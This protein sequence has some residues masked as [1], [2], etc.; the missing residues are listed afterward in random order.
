MPTYNE[1]IIKSGNVIEVY[2]YENKIQ[3][4]FDKTENKCGR[5]CVANEENK[6]LN[7]EKVI[8]RARTSI[9]RIVNC[10]V[11]RNSKFVTLTFRED[12]KDLN[13]ANYE[14]NKFIKR[15]KYKIKR[16]I[17]YLTVIE[18]QDKNRDGVIH[19]H[20]IFFNLPYI[21][22]FALNRIWKNGF[23]RIN[24]IDNVDNVGAY[25]CKYMSKDNADVRLQEKKCF[26]TSQKLKQPIEILRDTMY[27]KKLSPIDKDLN[28]LIP[29]YTQSFINEYNSVDYKQYILPDY[30]K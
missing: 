22:N 25:V 8:N 6:T 7:R 3:Y 18:F 2:K 11:T 19:Y 24:R 4:G 14:F 29:K 10:N 5:I 23:I 28:S 20:T 13:I 16:N 9:R 26:F 21:S 17:S 15:L 12:I 30:N 27:E 1:K